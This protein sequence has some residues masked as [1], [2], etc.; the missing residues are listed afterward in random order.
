VCA[1][2]V[3]AKQVGVRVFGKYSLALCVCVCVCV[4]S[5]KARI[6]QGSRDR[7]EGGLL[8]GRAESGEKYSM[9]L[10]GRQV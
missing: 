6:F 1:C 9:R 7:E 10:H 2:S 8:G 4:H 5:S 3:S